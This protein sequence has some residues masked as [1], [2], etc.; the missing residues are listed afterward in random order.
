MLLTVSLRTK[1]PLSKNTTCY[2]VTQNTHT[3]M[4]H[5]KKTWQERQNDAGD[6]QT[7]R[8]NRQK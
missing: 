8:V 7:L 6:K 3:Y 5:E 2:K 4:K 1:Q